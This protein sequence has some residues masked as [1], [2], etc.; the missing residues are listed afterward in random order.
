MAAKTFGIAHLY[1]VS[2]TITN[3]TVMSVNFSDSH[4][5]EDATVDESGIE[6]ERRYDDVRTEGTITLKLRSTYTMPT[7]GTTFVWKT[8]TYEI[9][10]ID[11]PEE[12]KGYRTITVTVKKS[13][14]ITYP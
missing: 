6:I 3:A 2:G 12:A 7:V 14:G 11:K 1:G 8:V 5:V 4:G 13:E 9:T 10:K